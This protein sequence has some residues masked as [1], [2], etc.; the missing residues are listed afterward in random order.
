M[1]SLK[2]TIFELTKN[3]VKLYIPKYQSIVYLLLFVFQ[4]AFFHS[5]TAQNLS[6]QYVQGSSHD[7][8]NSK[9]SSDQDDLIDY[10]NDDSEEKEDNQENEEEQEVDGEIDF[11][12]DL[13]A[14]GL[15]QDYKSGHYNYSSFYRTINIKE[16][17]S[18]PEV[19]V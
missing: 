1:L 18:P 6:I 7:S 14:S 10:E 17:F 9:S 8:D 13:S 11:V 12:K 2:F 15:Y 19:I 4:I 5:T 16:H 3:A